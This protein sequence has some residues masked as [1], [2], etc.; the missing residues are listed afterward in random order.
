MNHE[1]YMK[2]NIRSERVRERT[3]RG[4]RRCKKDRGKYGLSGESAKE[5]KR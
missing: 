1:S 5:R 3:Y 4:L 2:Y